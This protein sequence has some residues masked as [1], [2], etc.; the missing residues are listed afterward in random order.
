MSRMNVEDL[1][2][3]DDIQQISTGLIG[4]YDGM[5]SGQVLMKIGDSITVIPIDDVRLYEMSEN[6][7]SIQ[8]HTVA[9]SEPKVPPSIDL[10]IEQLAPEMLHQ[11]PARI[12]DFQLEKLKDYL[13]KASEQRLHQVLIIHGKG[14]G[15]LR[16]EVH[17]M[18]DDYRGI[19]FKF[20]KNDG[21]AT[22]VWLEI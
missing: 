5:R 20:D 10:H 3:G 14:T 22:E 6:D 19:R 11:S 2:I 4:K 9:K 12:L 15:I 7:E 13:D 18:L 1:W 21:G 17:H 16:S 8:T